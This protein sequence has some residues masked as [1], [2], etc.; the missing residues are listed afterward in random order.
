MGEYLAALLVHWVALMS[1]IVGLLI[2]IGLRIGR[3]TSETIKKWNDI[4]DW[5]FIC[6]G[7]ILL[8]YA[9]YKAWDDQ[10]KQVDDLK[11]KLT[12]EMDKN[13]IKLGGEIRQITTVTPSGN[14]N[15]LGFL[16]TVSI[17]NSGADSA[18][19]GYWAK[20][21]FENHILNN[22]QS[23][24]ISDEGLTLHGETG[25]PLRIY[26]PSDTIYEKTTT[27][28]TKGEFRTGIIYFEIE[29]GDKIKDMESARKLDWI[30]YFTDYLGK[31]Y[32]IYFKKEEGHEGSV[33]YF[34]GTGG[35]EPK[36]K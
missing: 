12:I 14:K 21:S 6:V 18:I 4:P 19:R 3:R 15:K 28:L 7:I 36:E 23:A 32:E 2:G 8:F 33:K 9:G 1:G 35:K 10:K 27:P 20:A 30:L 26:F 16:F 31:V 29:K 24:M 13:T 22:I 5:L 25:K 11:N 34:P 17:W